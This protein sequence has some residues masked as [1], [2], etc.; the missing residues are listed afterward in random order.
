MSGRNGLILGT[1]SCSVIVW[2]QNGGSVVSTLNAMMDPKVNGWIQR[3]QCS[4]QLVFFEEDLSGVPAWL[5]HRCILCF[6]HWDRSICLHNLFLALEKF[7]LKHLHNLPRCGIV[8]NFVSPIFQ[9]IQY[10]NYLRKILYS[11]VNQ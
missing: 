3:H 1:P 7:I 8:F 4:P 6:T 10:L 9:P 2:G 11:Y 5:L